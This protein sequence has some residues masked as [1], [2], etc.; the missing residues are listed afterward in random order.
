MY[1][2]HAVQIVLTES[3]LPQFFQA[4]VKVILS[5]GVIYVQNKSYI[6]WLNILIL[7]FAAVSGIHVIVTIG[8][9]ID[10]SDQSLRA[11]FG[12]V[13]KREKEV[14]KPLSGGAAPQGYELVPVSSSSAGI[15]Q[16]PEDIHE[17]EDNGG[18]APVGMELT[19]RSAPDTG[20]NRGVDLG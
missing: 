16:C 5:I 17:R 8:S 3:R 13:Y 10:I 14:E 7:P 1:W 2:L 19:G 9:V 20:L 18:E 11:A 6:M 4:L 15:V 12:L